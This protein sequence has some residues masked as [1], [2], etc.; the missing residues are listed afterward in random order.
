MISKYLS[1]EMSVVTEQMSQHLKQR[2]VDLPQ[3]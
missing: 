1:Y 2:M 3:T